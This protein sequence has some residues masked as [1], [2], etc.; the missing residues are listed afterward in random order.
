[1]FK[2]PVYQT[3]IE[4]IEK[5][6]RTSS[7][8]ASFAGVNVKTVRDVLMKLRH[9][10]VIRV[11]FLS[12]PP[13]NTPNYEIDNPVN[14]ITN[15]GKESRKVYIRKAVTGDSPGRPDEAAAWM[16]RK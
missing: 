16:K 13:S 11:A 6:H 3:V 15:G 12:P 7:D 8:I 10:R 5:G 1:M 14:V 4:A 9:K 2:S